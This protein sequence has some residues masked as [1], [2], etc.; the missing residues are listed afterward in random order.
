MSL[1]NISKGSVGALLLTVV[2]TVGCAQPGS[3]NQASAMAPS[4]VTSGAA[5]SAPQSGTT[6]QAGPGASYDASG[7]YIVEAGLKRNGEPFSDP[8]QI[9]LTQDGAGN[10]HGVIPGGHPTSV[11]LVRRG[12]GQTIEYD[13]SVFE[14][15]TQCN[16]VLSGQAQLNTKTGVMKA[17]LSGIE[18]DCENV[19]YFITATLVP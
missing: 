5:L 17:H 1:S 7:T 6:A 16:T 15:H 18:Q 4:S 8:D 10:L 3:S 13:M 11:T 14:P 2:G 12:S 9:T 19:D